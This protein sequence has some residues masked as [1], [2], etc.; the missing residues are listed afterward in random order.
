MERFSIK[1][2]KPSDVRP[3]GS[4]PSTM[5]SS[6]LNSSSSL[7]THQS[8]N[9]PRDSMTQ[10]ETIIA[11]ATKMAKE[12][13]V[14]A[15]LFI[16]LIITA[17]MAI[18]FYFQF[19]ELKKNPQ[20]LAQKEVKQLVERVSRLIVLPEGETPTMA[21]VTDLEK[22]KDQP[23]FSKA[24]IGDKVLIYTNAKKAILYDPINNKIVEVAPLNIGSTPSSA[25][26]PTTTKPTTKPPP[27]AAK[28]P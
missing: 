11:L 21:T 18:Y 3:E 9:D 20:D 5:R 23:F 13:M 6:G 28:K 26:T 27:P 2:A 4:V 8:L 15:V 16:A 24:K 14:P 25:T 12:K 19:I 17:S 22:L 7:K 1:K 10:K